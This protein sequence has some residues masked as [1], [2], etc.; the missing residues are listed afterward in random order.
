[1]F[2]ETTLSKLSVRVR[3]C[4]QFERVQMQHTMWHCG[5]GG[6]TNTAIHCK[7]LQ[8]PVGRTHLKDGGNKESYIANKTQGQ[9]IHTHHPFENAKK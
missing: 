3:V 4:N 6:L 1:M 5:L 9:Y 7:S 2:N 8:I